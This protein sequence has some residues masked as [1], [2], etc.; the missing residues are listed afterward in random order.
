MKDV[1]NVVYRYPGFYGSN[2]E[3]VDDGVPVLRG[4]HIKDDGTLDISSGFWSVSTTTSESFPKTALQQG[5]IVMAVR[6]TVGKFA[7]VSL[8][9]HGFQISPNLIRLSPNPKK[10][11]SDFFR[12]GVHWAVE[13]LRQ[14]TQQQALPALNAKDINCAPIPLPPLPEQKKIAAILSSVDE[15][16]Q[17]TQAVI[18]QTRRVKEGLLQDL[19]TRGIGHTRF[20][21]TELGELPEGW[22]VLRLADVFKL[23]SGKSKPTRTL[24]PIATGET[25]V[26]V[27]GG[28]GITGFTNEMLLSEPAIVIG[29]VGEYCGNVLLTDGAAWITDNA[30]YSKKLLRPVRLQFLMYLL[31]HL[32]LGRLRKKGGQPLVTQGVIGEVKVALPPLGEQLEIEERVEATVIAKI[33]VS[34]QLKQLQ[35]VKAGLL[36]DL[37]TGKVRV[38][39]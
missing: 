11:A 14:Q 17:A 28:N 19:L 36:Q 1:C 27:Y 25:S 22:E 16:I 6:G 30:L 29:R 34:N 26:P 35:Q 21:Q 12:H 18:E 20:K 39:V 32:K 13:I 33:A 15:A 23:T 4:E 38:S 31:Q 10:V 37:L 3:V 24:L 2:I 9:E 5:D 8:H 7:Q